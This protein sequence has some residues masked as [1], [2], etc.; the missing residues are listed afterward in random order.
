MIDHSDSP[1]LISKG[2]GNFARDVKTGFSLARGNLKAERA[3]T[4]LSNTARGAF[5]ES[6]QAGMRGYGKD[7]QAANKGAKARAKAKTMRQ[8]QGK[9]E[10][11]F[12]T[13]GSDKLMLNAS[14]SADAATSK[15]PRQL[16]F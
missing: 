10:P 7:Y 1:F 14:R 12:R 5:K 11:L 2:L 4:G 16:G 3:A 15:K 13:L 8:I 6:V 9:P